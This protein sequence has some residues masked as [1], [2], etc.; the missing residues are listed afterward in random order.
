MSVTSPP[1]VEQA[2]TM[3]FAAAGRF[4]DLV[5]G[6]QPVDPET[7]REVA[8][9]AA[10][11]FSAYNLPCNWTSGKKPRVPIPPA[12]ARDVAHNIQRVL[13]GHVPQWIL[14]LVK[15]GAPRAHP[16]MRH[17]IGL[18]VAYKKLCDADLIS[19]RHSTKTIADSYGVTR[20]RVQGWMRE[21]AYSE[22]TDWFPEAADE[23]ERASLIQNA[24][25]LAAARYRQ[26]GR[27]PRNVRPHGKARRRP[28]AK[29]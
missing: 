16:K 12:L 23:V 20:R 7:T 6:K 29:R 9:C 28:S 8:R 18:A 3:Y 4:N 15:K 22:P 14:Q 1:K 19:D 13:E 21:Y 5:N 27:A 10:M 24:L 25:P 2:I 11:V 17:D 26:W